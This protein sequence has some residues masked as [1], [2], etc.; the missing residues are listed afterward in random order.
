ME[1]YRATP[2][3]VVHRH[4]SDGVTTGFAISGVGL[5]TGYLQRLAVAREYRRRGIGSAL[6][7]SAN[8]WALTQGARAMLVNTQMDNLGAAE[9]YR[10]MGFAEV[11]GGLL[12]FRYQPN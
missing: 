11:V 5:G 7:K 4:R 12:L 2:G 6:V 1:S 10:R 3:A 8:R 9:L